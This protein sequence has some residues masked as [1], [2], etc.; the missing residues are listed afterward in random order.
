VE[1]YRDYMTDYESSRAWEN[2]NL[3]ILGGWCETGKLRVQTPEALT[4]DWI[5]IIKFNPH[6]PN[7]H[8]HPHQS[9]PW[10]RSTSL[11]IHTISESGI[12]LD[13]I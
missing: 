3:Q 1:T 9:P 12:R 5:Q 2:R 4:T 13:A 10:K 8:T 6:P 11:W 7:S